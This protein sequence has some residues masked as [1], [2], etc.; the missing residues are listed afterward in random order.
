MFRE[1][2]PIAPLRTDGPAPSPC[3][4]ALPVLPAALHSMQ[5][6]WQNEP[7]APL[8][9]TQLTS[10]R[11]TPPLG[12]AAAQR[13]FQS[14]WL[15]GVQQ[16]GNLTLMRFACADLSH[17][18]GT[19]SAISLT[20]LQPPG[21]LVS[22]DSLVLPPGGFGA[23]CTLAL[24]MAYAPPHAIHGLQP[25]QPVQQQQQ[26]GGQQLGQAA[27][28]A[29]QAAAWAQM[30]FH[31]A[32]GP[33][34]PQAPLQ[35]Q[36]QQQG[37]AAAQAPAQQQPQQPGQQQP[38]QQQP[39]QQ[40]VVEIVDDDAVIDLVE[41]SDDEEGQEPPP[42]QQQQAQ[43]QQQQAP[44]QAQVQQQQQQAPQQ[45]QQQAA[46]AAQGGPAQLQQLQQ[47]V[48]AVQG[49]AAQLAQ[50]VQQ[51][52]QAQQAVAALDNL[53]IAMQAVD[54]AMPPLEAGG[55]DSD[56]EDLQGGGRSVVCWW[57]VVQGP[58][59]ACWRR[60]RYGWLATRL[61]QGHGMGLCKHAPIHPPTCFLQ[62]SWMPLMTRQASCHPWRRSW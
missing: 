24:R 59:L 51:A 31:G 60:A 9:A 46:L 14:R 8:G 7:Q 62:A 50:H 52:Q 43:Q 30:A 4:L 3:C 56:D 13:C 47:H 54:L 34:V 39:Q 11:I 40:E 23:D 22:A 5:G 20:S 32:A 49:A 58:G 33:G 21:G 28:V 36:A 35:A 15:R 6:T 16:L 25:G 10:L 1:L 12:A 48:Q 57:C 26:A 17:I 19:A 45:A 29:A 18:R 38:Q 2:H 61:L 42:Q 53:G 44:Q 55:S 37:P 41:G 27:A